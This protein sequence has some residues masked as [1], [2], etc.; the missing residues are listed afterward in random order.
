MLID[1]CAYLHVN[2]YIEAVT[3]YTERASYGNPFI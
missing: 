1:K 2:I 3:L